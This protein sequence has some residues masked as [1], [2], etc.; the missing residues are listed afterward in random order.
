MDEPALTIHLIDPSLGEIDHPRDWQPA[1]IRIDVPTERWQDL[2]LTI[3]R[4]P[5]PLSLRLIN[6][7]PCITAEWLRSGP[8]NYEI[9]IGLDDRVATRLVT[10]HPAKIGADAYRELLLDLEQR[11][12]VAVAL[13]LQ[14]TGGLAGIVLPPPGESTVAQEATRLRRALL[15]TTT[16]PGLLSVLESLAADHHVV[17]TRHEIWTQAERARRPHPARLRQALMASDNLDADRRPVRVLDDRVDPSVDTYENRLVALFAEQVRQ[18]LRRLLRPLHLDAHSPLRA[19]LQ[20]LQTRLDRARRH[21]HFLDAVSRSVTA[22]NRTTMVLLKRPPYRAALAGFLELHRSISVRIEEPAL[23]S[24]LE[25]LPALYQIWGTLRVIAILLDV[26]A[27]AGYTD[28]W[29]SLVTRD[30]EG[31]FVRV[32]RDGQPAVVLR[33]P[34]SRTTIRCIPERTYGK[35]G[36]L[37]SISYDQRPDI[38]IE[39]TA[40]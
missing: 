30:H 4:L 15:G 20:D 28:V 3:Q 23:E 16:R 9:T 31:A 1:Q 12:P 37:R 21:A 27:K 19:E 32:L 18:R 24:P 14:R 33:H 35:S 5:A 10:I 26:A 11:L 38:A 13:G 34:E 17:L 7:Q 8:G 29:Q 6:G 36:P 2:R 40:P 25:N 39:I 22:P